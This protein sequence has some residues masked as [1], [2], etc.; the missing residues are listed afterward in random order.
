[1]L[2]FVVLAPGFYGEFIRF[3]DDRIVFNKIKTVGVV[4]IFILLLPRSIQYARR[5]CCVCDIFDV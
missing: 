1:M 4:E 3:N 2:E 5:Q